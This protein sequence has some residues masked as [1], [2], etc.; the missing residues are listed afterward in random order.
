M[1]SVDFLFHQIIIIVYRSD[2]YPTIQLAHKQHILFLNKTC[3]IGTVAT[4]YYS[5]W[6]TIYDASAQ[7]TMDAYLA[8]YR[9]VQVLLLQVNLGRMKVSVSKEYVLLV[10]TLTPIRVY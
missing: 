8:A 10:T 4:G 9:D 2:L 3:D 5:V 7:T 6:S 1:C